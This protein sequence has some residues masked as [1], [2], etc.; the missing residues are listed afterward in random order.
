MWEAILK[1]FGR[2]EA[3]KKPKKNQLKQQYGNFKA[4]ANTSIGKGKINTASVPTTSTQVSPASADVTAASISH[5]NDIEEMDI[6]WNM[7]LL[8]MMMFPKIRYSTLNNK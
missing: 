1:T 3:T 5:D 8:S 7:A 6:K 4:E 2:N